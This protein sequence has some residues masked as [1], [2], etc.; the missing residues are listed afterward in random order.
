MY[1]VAAGGTI[2]CDYNNYIASGNAGK[3][4]FYG[5]DAASLPIVTSQDANSK[6]S[7]VNF[8]STVTPNMHL[9]G[10]S[11]GDVNLAGTPI[12][13]VTTDI[14]GETRSTNSP[15]IGADEVITS[16]MPVE[17]T[18]F[19]ASTGLNIVTL[20]WKTAIEINHF[21]FE[22]EKN[23]SK[24]HLRMNDWRRIGFGEG[25]GTTNAQKSYSFVDPSEPGNYVY[26]LKQI[27]RNG[28][29][30][31]SKEIEVNVIDT[32]KEFT[33]GPNF[34]NPF[35]PV[36]VINYQLPAA[37]HV[38]LKIIDILGNDIATLVNESK[39]IGAYSVQ[40]NASKLSSGVYFAKLPS[41]GK[42]RI[43]KLLLLK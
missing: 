9:T 3:L 30:E 20:N 27:D 22:I 41:S 4:G 32:P 23:V 1:I 21:G 39:E 19:S 42:S 28:T 31:Y 24:Q 35:N 14:D 10:A 6:N 33:L 18:P 37:R 5:A 29:F 16:P 17:L 15:Y 12:A 2:T 11:E 40:F 8:I 26:R 36:T 25:S 43:R 34:P 7:A 13:G 38:S